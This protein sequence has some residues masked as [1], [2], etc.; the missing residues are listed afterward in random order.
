MTYGPGWGPGHRSS[1]VASGQFSERRSRSRR[2]H[3]YRELTRSKLLEPCALYVIIGSYRRAF[4][5]RRI[6]SARVSLV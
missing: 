6:S 4:M 5:N 1:H 3:V 2:R